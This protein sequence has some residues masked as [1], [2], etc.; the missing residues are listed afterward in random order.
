[1]RA[2]VRALG[3]IITYHAEVVRIR[4][5]GD[6]AQ[7]TGRDRRQG[8]VRSLDADLVI[9]TIPLPVLRDIPADFAEPV[10]RA[11]EVGARLYVPAVK[12]AFQSNRRW[13]ETDHQIY[14][15]IT[16]TGRDIT[17]LWYP[18]HGIHAAKGIVIGA[19]I[20]TSAIGERFAAMPPPERHRAAIADGA[21]IHG[22]YAGL[23][24]HGGSG[25][26]RKGPGGRRA[27]TPVSADAAAGPE[28]R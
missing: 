16:W 24:E 27:P 23:G 17:Q 7:V 11:I 18:S 19:Y 12:I 4:R 22:G 21:R 3:P 9:C 20:W 6:R 8:R 10:K 14:G 1:P 26:W 2:F 13:W 28:S 25:A 5:V 15:G